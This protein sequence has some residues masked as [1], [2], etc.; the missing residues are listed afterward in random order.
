MHCRYALYVAAT[1]K[2]NENLLR[3]VCVRCGVIKGS[4]RSKGDEEESSEFGTAFRRNLL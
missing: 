3:S 1:L 4:K 2:L